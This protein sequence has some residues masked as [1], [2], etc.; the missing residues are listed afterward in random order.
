MLINKYPDARLMV[1]RISGILVFFITLFAGKG[2]WL[3]FL[4][5]L[6]VLFAG[7]AIFSY[8]EHYFN[9]YLM[10]LFAPLLLFNYASITDFRIRLAVFLL[11]TFITY[12]ASAY[13]IKTLSFSLLKAKP[14]I[15]WLTA[16]LILF[17]A[18]FF[19]Y[20]PGVHL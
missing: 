18:S 17:A 4:S 10:M 16:L 8:R 3:F 1:F 6:L 14:V 15:I 2:G 20:Y 7:E 9:P 13:P 12:T 19:L 11:F 5:T